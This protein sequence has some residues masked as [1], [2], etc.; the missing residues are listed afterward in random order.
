ME[1]SFLLVTELGQDD[2]VVATLRN[3]QIIDKVIS[4]S[5]EVEALVDRNI[6]LYSWGKILPEEFIARQRIVLNV[7]NSLLPRYRGRHAFTWALIHGERSVGYTLHEVVKKPDAGDIYAQLEILLEPDDDI[8]T[9]FKKGSENMVKWLP[10]QL[11]SI[12][13]GQLNPIKQDETLATSFPRRGLSDMEINLDWDH[14]RIS[15]FIRAHAPPYTRGAYIR[16]FGRLFFVEK[17]LSY[18]LKEDSKPNLDISRSKDCIF[19]QCADALL[20]LKISSI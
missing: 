18:D 10:T 20:E 12:S 3:L 1:P 16:S 9:V 11:K 2:P 15:N 5:S 17:I 14:L 13:A 8:N 6:V 7:H 4:D 19:V